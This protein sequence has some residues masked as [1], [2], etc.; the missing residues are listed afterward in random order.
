MWTKLIWR[1]ISEFQKRSAPIPP[2]QP[3]YSTLPHAPRHSQSIDAKEIRGINSKIQSEYST[4]PHARHTDA[5]TSLDLHFNNKIYEPLPFEA[6]IEPADKYEKHKYAQPPPSEF[7]TFGHK[8][9]LSGES[10]GRNLHLAGAKLVLPSGEIPILKPVDKNVIRPKL[11]PPG[12]PPPPI[13]SA[14]H[15]SHSNNGSYNKQTIFDKLILFVNALISNLFRSG[16]Q[17]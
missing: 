3:I 7:T 1:N 11:P 9:S 15:P 8:R 4:L 2:N 14:T 16:Q 13:S 17:P 12:P 5:K 10:I 6:E